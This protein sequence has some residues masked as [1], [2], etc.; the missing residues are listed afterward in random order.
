MARYSHIRNSFLIGEVSPKFYG[1]T[2][3]PQYHQMC[4]KVLNF[5]TMPQ[6][7]VTRRRGTR[8]FITSS[9][10]PYDTAFQDNTDYNN[11]AAVAMVPYE[12]KH[13][14][15]G[16]F[17]GA[18]ILTTDKLTNLLIELEAQSAIGQYSGS[19]TSGTYGTDFIPTAA[20]MR[21][22]QWAQYG[23][24]LIITDGTNPPLIISKNTFG[25]V[26]YVVWGKLEFNSGGALDTDEQHRNFP[27][28]DENAT[29][30][31]MTINTASVG[32]GRT[33]TASSGVFSAAM[34]G[35]YI[36]VRDA[37]TCGVAKITA[38]TS[39]TVVTVEVVRAFAG[40]AAYTPWS[41]AQWGGDRGWPAT[42]AFFEERLIFANSPIFPDRFWASQVNDIFEFSNPDPSDTAYNTLLTSSFSGSVGQSESS[43]IN[44]LF[45]KEK[46]FTVT[47]RKECYLDSV[48][49]TFSIGRTNTRVV[50]NSRNG[51]AQRQP[52]GMGEEIVY[53]AKDRF[54]LLEID[55]ELRSEKFAVVNL[56]ETAPDIIRDRAIVDMGTEIPEFTYYSSG[57][58]NYSS[59]VL[60]F[61]KI[62]SQTFPYSIVWAIDHSGRLYSLTKRKNPGALAWAHHRLGGTL[63]SGEPKVLDICTVMFKEQEYVVL[64]VRREINSTARTCYE[65]MTGDF[66]AR[67]LYDTTYVNTPTLTVIGDS[68]LP[69]YMDYAYHSVLSSA[70]VTH[71]GFQHLASQS[72]SVVADGSYIGELTVASNGTLTLPAVA[73]V[74]IAGFKY[75]S[76]LIPVALDNNALF[77]TGLGSIKR[78]EQVFI[79]FERTVSALVGVASDED[80]LKDINFREASVSASDPTPLFTGEK[81]IKLM[82][83]YESKQNILIRQE[84]PYPMTVNAIIA[85]G[86]LYD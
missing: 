63:S 4:E 13:V 77:G 17:T 74:V 82:A 64:A 61:K 18:V 39:A 52:V 47:A 48:D 25:A 76:D 9:G 22:T 80:S 81:E 12:E 86:I 6:G 68:A 7:G 56:S 33:L 32:T 2:D 29:A 3:L 83:S 15:T 34:I 65:Y 28:D 14:T 19:S 54:N 27:Y 45:P 41:F 10:T 57:Y 60:G 44:I 51:A 30:I 31:T 16:D 42:V 79:E 36:R 8:A 23:K 26:A 85:K 66:L 72:V 71:P 11:E 78:T 69:R 67:E 59:Q 5:V 75:T 53:V 20:T 70:S 35:R 1:R 50:N 46:F 38:Y 84:D 43:Q 73:K 37:S 21:T 62:C 58:V 40:T 49:T 24:T 55:F